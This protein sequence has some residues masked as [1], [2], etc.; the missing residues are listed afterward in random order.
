MS[1]ILYILSG[2]PLCLVWCGFGGR[3]EVK[4]YVE[5]SV[6]LKGDGFRCG[7]V[8][9]VRD[10]FPRAR[11][12]CIAEKRAAQGY[13]DVGGGL[14]KRPNRC[15]LREA[16]PRINRSAN[17]ACQSSSSARQGSWSFKLAWG[18]RTHAK[19]VPNRA[20]E[21]LQRRPIHAC[22]APKRISPSRLGGTRVSARDP[23][24]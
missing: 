15:S 11:F 5:R 19:W 10:G 16:L 8:K 23:T 2:E 4:S 1:F 6:R 7:R 21:P 14:G 18:G 12:W 20:I 22:H 24:H 9:K 13:P 17:L 3:K